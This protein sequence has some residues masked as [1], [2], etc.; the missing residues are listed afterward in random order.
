MILLRFKRSISI[1]FLVSLC[2]LNSGCDWDF[3]FGAWGIFYTL[4]QEQQK[5]KEAKARE[6]AA[7]TTYLETV[8]EVE[9]GVERFASAGELGVL[10]GVEV[11]RHEI[12]MQG[13]STPKPNPPKESNEAESPEGHHHPSTAPQQNHPATKSE[14]EAAA[15]IERYQTASDMGLLPGLVSE[16]NPFAV[17]DNV[18]VAGFTGGSSSS[19]TVDA[20]SMGSGGMNTGGPQ[21]VSSG[22]PHHHDHSEY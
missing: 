14:A 20:R 16:E 10:P 2:L 3:L 4:G 8:R 1:L 11:T 6:E 12:F 18:G 17:A 19:P 7:K 21:P 9:P 5:E 13:H 22:T 15:A